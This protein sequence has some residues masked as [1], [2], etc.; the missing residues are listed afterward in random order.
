M[1][2]NARNAQTTKYLHQDLCRRSAFGVNGSPAMYQDLPRLERVPVKS[3]S[4]VPVGLGVWLAR[5]NPIF[6]VKVASCR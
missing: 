4:W 3:P 6:W 5:L 2:S 1:G